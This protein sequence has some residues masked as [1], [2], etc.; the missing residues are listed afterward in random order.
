[1]IGASPL[2]PW[3]VRAFG[4]AE[5]RRL[6]PSDSADPWHARRALWADARRVGIRVLIPE[7]RALFNSAFPYGINDGP[8]WAGRG[9]TTVLEVG[10][11]GRAGPISL[12]VAPQIFRAENA[13]FGLM[14]T[15]QEGRLAFADGRF[16]GV[17]DLPQ[18]FGDSPYMRVDAG[19]STLRADLGP[20]A[21][22][23]STANQYWGPAAEHP[24]LLGNNA[25]G[26]QHAFVGTARPVNLWLVR[27]HSRVIWGR[28]D[29]SNYSPMEPSASRRFATGLVA[30]VNPRGV[31]GLELGAARFFHM[32]W[33]ERGLRGARFGKAFESLLKVDLA[34][35]RPNV[36][37]G[38][39]PDNQLASVFGRWVFPA[40]GFEIYGEYGREDHNWDLRTLYLEPDHDAAYLLGFVKAWRR[41]RS[42][43]LAVRG[44]V[45]NSR[46]S[47]LQQAA[48]QTPFYLHGVTRQGHTQ[49]GQILGSA[50]GYGGG[51][52]VVAVE[53]YQPGGRLTLAWS[54]LMRGEWLDPASGL[55]EA[56]RADV[57]HTLRAESLMFFSRFDVTAGAT[58]VYELNRDFNRDAFNLNV[59][60][61]ARVRW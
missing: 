19:Q 50:A 8:V 2:H 5:L 39:D 34:R 23:F 45:L 37:H 52:A 18:R 44:E 28:L 1:V 38:E 31:P 55:P 3:S 24:I 22:G 7:V 54:R 47:H 43:L 49:L 32:P 56:R 27:L 13:R 4:P 46:I 41:S 59:A 35:K 14:P 6:V 40:S 20:I 61:G 48:P 29:Q 11:V 51:A 16:P 60:L 33:P 57:M 26:F 10:V 36:V 30:A 58:G 12:V 42:G 21:L 25:G 53:A 9:I 17:I 15:G